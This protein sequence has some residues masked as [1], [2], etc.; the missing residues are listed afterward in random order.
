MPLISTSAL[1]L[2][3]SA[4]V[5]GAVCASAGSVGAQKMPPR[6]AAQRT[7][8]IRIRISPSVLPSGGAPSFLGAHP[9][10]RH[11]PFLGEKAAFVIHF[12]RAADP[13]AEIHV[14]KSHAFC[15]RNM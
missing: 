14:S 6:R 7:A 11:E 1:P 3:V 4:L 9:T 8:T 15:P 10:V 2:S 12:A 5:G 13:V